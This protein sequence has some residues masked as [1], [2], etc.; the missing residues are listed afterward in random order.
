MQYFFEVGTYIFSV[1]DHQMKLWAFE[2]L[3]HQM[4]TSKG[5]ASSIPEGFCLLI[6]KI[7]ELCQEKLRVINR[8]SMEFIVQSCKTSNYNESQVSFYLYGKNNN[9]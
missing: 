6:I 1:L 5:L 9:L 8:L 2:G 7:L 4:G 3:E